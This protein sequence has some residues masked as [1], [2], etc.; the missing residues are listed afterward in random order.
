M[1]RPSP[2]A[3]LGPARLTLEVNCR[4]WADRETALRI[5]RSIMFS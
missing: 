1:L 5:V 2:L 4:E 3:G